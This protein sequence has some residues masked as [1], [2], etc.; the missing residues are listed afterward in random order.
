MTALQ[1]KERYTLEEYLALERS[2]EVRY[3]YHRGQVFAMAGGTLAHSTI[4]HNTAG[5]L[6]EATKRTGKCFSFNSETKIEISPGGRYVYPD[7][8]LACPT[9]KESDRLSGAI[10]N[11]TLLVE[12]VNTSSADYDRGEK[13]HYYFSLP[14]LKEYL[15]IHQDHFE[16]T[17]YRRRGDLMRIDRYQGLAAA[18][19]LESIEA[20]ILLAD[21]YRNV[22][23]PEVESDD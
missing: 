18:V 16:V 9:A 5:E 2:G 1:E 13:M 21:I 11:P 22:Q 19:P 17:I 14:T 6:R 20:E 7:A 23:L 4:C 15:L 12:V 8:G 10:I 3:E